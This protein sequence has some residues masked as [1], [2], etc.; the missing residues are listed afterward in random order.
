MPLEVETRSFISKEQYEALMSF[1]KTNAKQSSTEDDQVTFYFES[2]TSD[3]VD[4]RIQQNASYSKVWLKK[5]RLHDDAR[6]EIEIR[7]Q[8]S[9][10]EKLEHLFLALG[11]AIQI[12]WFRR[13]NEFLWNEISV[14]LDYTRGYGYIVEFEKLCEDQE[15]ERVQ[16]SLQE[17]FDSLGIAISRREEFEEKYTHYKEHWRELTKEEG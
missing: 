12:K 15:K 9:D 4:L 13:R 8:L 1:F 5:G 7:C 11:Y 3:K 2:P 6:E 14:A 16:R 17:A 10:F